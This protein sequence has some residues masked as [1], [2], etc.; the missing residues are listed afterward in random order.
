[1]ELITNFQ[2]KG[3]QKAQDFVEDYQV[4]KSEDIAL[5]LEWVSK[6]QEKGLFVAGYFSYESMQAFD[7]TY[8]CKQDSFP[9]A[10]FYAFK[11]LKPIHSQGK[12]YQLSWKKEID[13]EQYYI[14]IKKVLDYIYEGDVYQ[15][16]YSF[17]QYCKEYSVDWV[18]FFCD[19]VEN[20]QVPYACLI[21]DGPTAIISLSPELFLKREDEKIITQPMK[22]TI[23]R[24]RYLQEDETQKSNLA[25]DIKSQAENIMIV[26][27]MRNDFSKICQI[28]SVKIKNKYEIKTFQTL[29]QMVTTVEER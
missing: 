16:N 3:L 15:V 11:S 4:N 28:H 17:R 18:S 1:M 26:D 22:G 27:L 29:H 8:A 24:G 14:N 21:V 23:K 7:T 13:S 19:L 2:G 25:Q 20:Q 6:Q 12:P 5:L 9:L 10:K